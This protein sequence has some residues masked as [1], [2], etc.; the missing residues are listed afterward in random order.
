MNAEEVRSNSGKVWKVSGKKIF[1]GGKWDSHVGPTWEESGKWDSHFKSGNSHVGNLHCFP[2]GKPLPTSHVGAPTWE[3]PL[4]TWD[5]RGSSHFPPNSHVGKLTPTWEKFSHPTPCVGTS[6]FP[7]WEVGT[8]TW[9][10]HF[11]L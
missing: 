7:T 10:S 4:P 3:F 11:P 9:E 6:H 5:P 1:L 2:R 8:P